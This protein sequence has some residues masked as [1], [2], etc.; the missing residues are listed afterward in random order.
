MFEYLF[1][2]TTPAFQPHTA[3]AAALVVASFFVLGLVSLLLVNK[4]KSDAPLSRFW[5]REANLW[6]TMGVI[7]AL[8]LFLRQFQIYI[9][10]ARIWMMLWLIGVIWWFV[11]LAQDFIKKIP[12]ARE[13]AEEE[14][15]RRKY[16]PRAR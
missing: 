12:Q 8:L 7:G 16:L 2:T 6:W 10:G 13:R 15:I 4:N 3:R 14:K 1:D 5:K 11:K 9:L